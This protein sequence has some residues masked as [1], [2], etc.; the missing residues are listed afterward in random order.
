MGKKIK[1][2]VLNLALSLIFF[3]LFTVSIYGQ[4]KIIGIIKNADNKNI[5]NASVVIENISGVILAYTYSNLNGKYELNITNKGNFI[6]QVSYLG[7][8]KKSNPFL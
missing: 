2:T 1:F 7:Y 4:T 8:T 3:N 5:E 6:L